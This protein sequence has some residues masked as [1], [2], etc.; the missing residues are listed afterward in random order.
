MIMIVDRRVANFEFGAPVEKVLYMHGIGLNN[1]GGTL[2]IACGG[3]KI[4]IY[5]LVS[6]RLLQTLSPHSKTITSLLQ[7]STS[8][9]TGSLDHQVKVIEEGEVVGGWGVSGPVVSLGVSVLLL[10]NFRKTKCM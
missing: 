2:A 8:I 3:T 1:K 5:D 7:T 6:S 10:S 9:L 4:K